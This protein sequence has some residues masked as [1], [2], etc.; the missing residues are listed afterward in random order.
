MHFVFS[1]VHVTL[2]RGLASP[3]LIPAAAASFCI[4]AIYSGVLHPPVNHMYLQSSSLIQQF[5]SLSHETF[6]VV[7][8]EVEELASIGV[9]IGVCVFGDTPDKLQPVVANKNIGSINK[10]IFINSL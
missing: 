5:S 10:I 3:F 7:E 4:L 9:V 1:H 2:S 8:T 6:G